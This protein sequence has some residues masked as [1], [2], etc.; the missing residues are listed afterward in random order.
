M[1]SH[2]FEEREIARVHGGVVHDGEPQRRRRR[3]AEGARQRRA[4]HRHLVAA[5]SRPVEHP[6]A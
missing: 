1:C 4:V 3:R 2:L 5:Q 6:G